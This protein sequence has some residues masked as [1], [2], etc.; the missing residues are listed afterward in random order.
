MPAGGSPGRTPAHGACPAHS[1][2]CPAPSF[3]FLQATRLKALTPDF[4][5]VS[6]KNWLRPS[7]KNELGLQPDNSSVAGGG[8]GEIFALGVLTS[9]LSC[10]P[11]LA[12]FSPWLAAAVSLAT[13]SVGPQGRGHV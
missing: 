1:G 4:T 11:S 2:A 10:G 12:A 13:C 5:L 3:A 7:C 9:K 6:H 8:G